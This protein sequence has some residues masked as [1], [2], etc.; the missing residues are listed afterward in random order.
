MRWN[1]LEARLRRCAEVG[2][3]AVYG[4]VDD[5][6]GVYPLY[7]LRTPGRAL[8]VIT[9]GFHGDE[10]AGPITLADHLPDIAGY[11]RERD[12]GLVIYPCLN[13]SGFDAFTRYNRLG[14]RPNNDVM[15]YEMPDGRVLSELHRPEPFVR[16]TLHRGGPQET[17]ALVREL[18]ELHGVA[19]ALDLHQDPYLHKPLTYAYAFG[20]REPHIALMEEG[21][22]HLPIARSFEVDDAVHTDPDGLI[23]LHDG[24]VTDWFTRRGTPYA[25]AIETTTCSPLDVCCQVNLAWI[26]GYVDLAAE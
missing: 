4:H 9:A 16:T 21:G 19:A 14:E 7:R 2:D 22:R 6:H 17:R 8:C 26:R 5:G 24:S 20:P 23:A 25:A 11:A 12:V 15:R 1:D 3:L 18:E 10:Q 13:P